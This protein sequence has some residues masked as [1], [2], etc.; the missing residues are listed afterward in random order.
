MGDFISIGKALSDVVNGESQAAKEAA[1]R[2]GIVRMS[3]QLDL[4]FP[5]D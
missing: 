1:G 5:Y 3:E 4:L 2:G